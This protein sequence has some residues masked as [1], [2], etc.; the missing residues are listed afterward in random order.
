MMIDKIS[1]NPISSAMQN[2]RFLLV[3]VS[4][5][6]LCMSRTAFAQS[7][8]GA[9]ASIRY[10]FAVDW[11]RE[12][13]GS[14]DKAGLK[15]TGGRVIEST[16]SNTYI[17]HARITNR[18]STAL[19]DLEVRI[20]MHYKA[21]DGKAQTD[22]H[23]ITTKKIPAIKQNETITVDTDPLVLKV[24]ELKGG[25]YYKDGS[26]SRQADS[27]RGAVVTLLHDG[28]QVFE[29]ISNPALKSAASKPAP[30]E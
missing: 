4:A 28:K 13:V 23:K 29:Y 16:T 7:G 5:M 19:N 26:P 25:Y 12:R 15:T 10:G 20:Q 21:A 6:M 9:Q 1:P 8:S 14:K 24:F 30:G 2:S 11:S 18:S 22:E 3:V 27:I 17:G